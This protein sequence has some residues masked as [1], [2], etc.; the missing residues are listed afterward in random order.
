MACRVAGGNHS[1][2][3]LWQSILA[4]KDASS[5]IPATRWEPYRRRD[6]RNAKVLDGTTSRGYFMDALEDFDPSFFGISPKEAEQMDPQQ[7][8]SMEVAWEALESAGI[9]PQSLS[10][11]Q[12]AV[13][14]G[15][16]SDDYSRLVL[17][18]LPNIEAWMGIGTAYCGVPNRISYH[19]NLMGA[20]TAIDAAC[21]SSLV[22]IHHGRQ[23]I[24]LGETKLA[25]V[26]GVNAL[27]GPGLFRVLDKAGAISSKGSCQS[28]DDSAHGY[29]RGEG[30]GAV[31]LKDLKDAIADNDRILAILKGSAVAQDGHT[32]GIMAPNADA[33]Q[34]VARNALKIAGIDPMTVRYVEAHATSTP[35]G[36]PTEISAISSV[37]GTGR[38]KESPCFIGSIKPNIG[39]LEAGAGVMSFIKAVLTINKG[40]LPPQ[41][42][43]SKLNSSVRW[44]D[45]GVCV[46]QDAIEWP[47]SD[48]IR[49]ASVCSYG[50]GGTVSHAVLEEF[51]PSSVPRT[52]SEQFGS[53]SFI[54]LLSAPQEKRLTSQA[55]KYRSWLL[56]DGLE[57]NFESIVTTLAIRRGHHDYRAALIADSHHEAANALEAVIQGSDH[58]WTARSRR[59]GPD[60]NKET[61]WVFSGHG[62]QWKEMGRDMLQNPVFFQAI[63]SLDDIVRA[64]M[65]FSAVNALQNGNFET[66]ERV[67]VLT[68]IMQIGLSSVLKNKGLIPQAIIG[69]SVGEIAA[70]V[71]SGALT[72]EEGV[73]VVCRR[74]LIYCQVV[75]LGSMILI[76]KPYTEIE[77]E[78]FGREAIS[79]AIDASPSSCVVSGSNQS[80][81]D[82]TEWC[83]SRGIRTFTVKTDIAFHSPMLQRLVDPLVEAL[84]GKLFPRSPVIK[85][86]STTLDDPRGEAVRDVQY[87]A[88]NMVKPVRLRTAVEAAIEDKYGIFLEI[89]SHPLVTH[90]INET[91][92]ERGIDDYAVIPTLVRNKPSEKCILYSIA[93]LHCKGVSVDWKKQ[94]P[95]QWLPEVPVSSWSHRPIWKTI[96]TGPF[97]P[98]LTPDTEKHTLLGQRISIAGT[99]TVVHVSKLDESTKPFP[100][101]HPLHGTEIVPAASLINTFIHGTGARAFQNVMLLVPVAVSVPREIQVVVHQDRVIL[102]SRLVKNTQK[103]N[104]L[105]SSWITHTTA[106][107]S[108]EFAMCGESERDIWMDTSSIKLRINHRLK[109]NFSIEYLE[110][111]GVSAMGFPWAISEHWGNSREMIAKFDVTP[112]ISSDIPLPWD[113]HS[114]A[115]AFDAATSVASTIFLDEPRLRMVAQIDQIS[116]CIGA[117]PPK[118][119]WLYIEKTSDAP[120]AA[121]ISILSEDGKLLAKLRGMRFS[122]I[123]GTTGVCNNSVESLV[124]QIAWPPASLGET[125]FALSQAI[126]VSSDRRTIENYVASLPTRIKSAVLTSAEAL[127][128]GNLSLI[129][130]RGTAII[131]VPGQVNTLDDVADAAEEFISQLL[132]IIK[133][134]VQTS[135]PS[136]VFV[137]TSR[138]AHGESP[139]ALAQAPL[140]GLSRIVASEQPDHFGGLIDTEDSTFPLQAI[141]YVQGGDVIRMSDGVARLARLRALPREK[142]L[143]ETGNGALSLLPRPEGTYLV[144]GGLGALGIEVADFLVQKGAR[145]LILISRRSFPLRK[146]WDQVKGPLASTVERVRGLENRGASIHVLALDIGAKDSRL[147]LSAAIDELSLPPIL[148]IVHAAGVLE[149]QL[150]LETTRSSFSRVLSPKIGGALTLHALFPPGTLDFFVLFSSC[151][152]LFGVPGQSS[153][154]SGNAFLDTLATHRRSISG[155]SDNAVAF[156]W[157]SWRGLGMA[158]STST[159]FINAEFESKGITDVTRDDAFRAWCHLARYN[160]DHAVVLRSQVFNPDEPLPVPILNDIAVRRSAHVAPAAA[161]TNTSTSGTKMPPSG[162]ELTAYLEIQIRE[163]VAAVLHSTLEDVDPRSAL[164]DQGLDSVMTIALRGQLQRALKIKVPPTLTWNHPTVGHLVK[165]FEDKV[166]G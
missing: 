131:Y 129:H 164:S 110:K 59:L 57:Y 67:Q 122:E 36:D 128:G 63:S 127:P 134:V 71:V 68:Y 77:R 44:E 147:Q 152:Q 5:A 163:C 27:C 13:Y 31:I 137:I 7:R 105:E 49:R 153:Y 104:D 84:S 109:D 81:K 101:K 126:F 159:S 138:V 75:G 35:L 47:V 142:L 42:N 102:A 73:L 4:K 39:H 53:Q 76:H 55:E 132:D 34:L 3:Q 19:L 160:T 9:P 120:L 141:R 139:T 156:Q 146:E 46:V 69:H 82:L 18:D 117:I 85:L 83:R 12:S 58:A 20:S 29:G 155:G 10:G 11:T 89:S 90:S 14:W 111:V 158:A 64:E 112:E 161:E 56:V 149:D 17:E 50:Y 28:F 166:R 107:W 98:G 74:A 151:G 25:I 21:A 51:T 96:E 103:D 78:L 114:W 148:G 15:V 32:N 66:S 24:L 124:H 60:V 113:P 38:S 143:P 45:A 135:L 93:Q 8:I 94:M 41:A 62:A 70:S 140:H 52:S 118:T 79:V 121:H 22:A 125:P 80:I 115:P 37:Y 100:G 88:A 154:A 144:S 97:N 92:I 54:L 2:E 48:K 87:W 1:P 165:W 23:A 72:P 99:N 30:V 119:G 91:I 40:I 106:Q 86:Y 26:G 16:G 145:R 157:T 130:D 123:E 33:Q 43:L 116:I 95:G 162:P 133:Y 136:K 65:G 61:V 108:E 150:V 6:A